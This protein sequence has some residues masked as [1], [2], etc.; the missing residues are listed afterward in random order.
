MRLFPIFPNPTSFLKEDK[1]VKVDMHEERLKAI[2]LKKIWFT[3][4]RCSKCE[5]FF[6]HEKMWEVYRWSVNETRWPWH[7]CQHCLPTKE[8]VLNEI[9]N[10]GCMFGIYGV[11]DFL[12]QTK[13]NLSPCDSP[14]V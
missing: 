9:D 11:D 8:D 2:K 12:R 6:V 14:A 7:Y 1:K 5:N 4:T 10:D 13:A 3:R